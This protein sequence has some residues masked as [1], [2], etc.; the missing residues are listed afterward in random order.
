MN[1]LIKPVEM[2]VIPKRVKTALFHYYL[3]DDS[4]AGLAQLITE[5][6]GFSKERSTRYVH[7]FLVQKNHRNSV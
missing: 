7:E 2:V 3:H 6:F 4:S 1:D 5:H